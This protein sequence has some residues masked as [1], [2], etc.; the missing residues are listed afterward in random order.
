MEE[1]EKREREGKRMTYGMVGDWM[2]AQE[3]NCPC[4]GFKHLNTMREKNERKGEPLS[5]S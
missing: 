5:I 3:C 1:E 4:L 2:K